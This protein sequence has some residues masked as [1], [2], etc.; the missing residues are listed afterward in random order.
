M[1][2]APYDLSDDQVMLLG[3]E[4]RVAQL[5]DR[6]SLYAYAYHDIFDKKIAQ[7]LLTLFVYRY[8]NL[9]SIF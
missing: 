2:I 1:I 7:K 4:I 3:P 9:E 5:S 6:P 8:P